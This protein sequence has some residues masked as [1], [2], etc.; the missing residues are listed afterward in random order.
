MLNLMHF[1]NEMIFLF[2]KNKVFRSESVKYI[3]LI[4]IIK[5]NITNIKII[6]NT[7]HIIFT[8]IILFL[9]NN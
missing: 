1:K 9:R 8:K 4:Y 3:Y 2:F 5:L 7:K 6:F